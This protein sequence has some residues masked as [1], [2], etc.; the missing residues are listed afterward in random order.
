[1]K[2]ISWLTD[3]I[4]H[5]LKKVIHQNRCITFLKFMIY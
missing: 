3:I 1:M 4:G 2:Q 5:E